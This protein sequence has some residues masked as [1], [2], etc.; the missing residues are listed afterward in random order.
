[1]G[2]GSSDEVVGIHRS[3]VIWGRGGIHGPR[4]IWGGGGN[5]LATGHLRRWSMELATC[6]L[7][8]KTRGK[9]QFTM[10]TGLDLTFLTRL[11]VTKNYW[12]PV[13]LPS[14]DGLSLI[15]LSLNSRPRPNNAHYVYICLFHTLIILLPSLLNEVNQ[16]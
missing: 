12:F 9:G 16:G 5:P 3:R 7:G 13:S 4:V 1:M 10:T 6:H 2:H 14:V 8:R 11:M 15:I